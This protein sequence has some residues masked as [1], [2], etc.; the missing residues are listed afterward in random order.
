MHINLRAVAATA[1][2]AIVFMLSLKACAQDFKNPRE[3]A[4]GSQ[5]I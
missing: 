5:E 4:L 2:L 1:V 3:P